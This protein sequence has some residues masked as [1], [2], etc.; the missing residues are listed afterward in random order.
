MNLRTRIAKLE[1]AFRHSWEPIIAFASSQAEARQLVD[2][3]RKRRGLSSGQLVP[4]IC[5]TG[6]ATR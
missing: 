2:E 1:S 4:T 3:E 5:V 6:S